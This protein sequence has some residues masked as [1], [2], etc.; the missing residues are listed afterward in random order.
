MIDAPE[1]VRVLRGCGVEFFAGVPDSLLKDFCACLAETL[2]PHRHVTTANEGTA[3]ALA[4]GY[5]LA[6]GGVPAVY[7]QNS[8]LGNAVNPLLSLADPDVYG[9]PLLLI[10]GWRAEPGVPD[11]PQHAKQGRVMLEMLRAMELPFDIIGPEARSFE[12]L[13]ESAVASARRRRGPHVIVVRKGTFS[14]YAAGP[15]QESALALSRE[16][17][18]GTILEV[19]GER[20][21]VVSTTGMASRELYELRRGRGEDDRADFLVVGSMGHCS[22]IA[23]G[24]ALERPDRRVFCLDGDGAAMMHMGGLA[25]IGLVGP[26]N[27]HHILLDNGAHDSVGGQSTGALGLDWPAVAGAVGYRWTARVDSSDGLRKALREIVEAPGPRFLEVRIR[28]GSRPDLGRPLSSPREGRD[29][30]MR[31]L[32]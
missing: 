21:V 11:E 5:H 16:A 10:V 30:F 4:T 17:A 18:I 1:L 23:L 28:T 2:P 31:S 20:D 3:V 12:P 27:Y 14:R 26:R 29:R 13:M 22:Q 9:I 6:T 24:I 25:T 19:L 8:G 7:L 15:R 32:A